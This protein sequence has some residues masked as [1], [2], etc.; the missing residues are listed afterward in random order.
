MTLTFT[1]GTEPHLSAQSSADII[2]VSAD[3]SNNR[4]RSITAFAKLL[5]GV[6]VGH[7]IWNT[8]Y[9][10]IVQNIRPYATNSSLTLTVYMV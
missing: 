1:N 8:F 3:F 5:S 6:R 4:M 9:H 10:L 7:Y 2:D